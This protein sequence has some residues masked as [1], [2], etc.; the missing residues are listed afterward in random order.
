[1]TFA[2]LDEARL[3]AFL[4]VLA[5][6]G[7]LFAALPFFS[8]EFLPL[9][10]RAVLAAGLSL[11]LAGLVLPAGVPPPPSAAV[12]AALLARE[13][14]LGLAAA[15]VVRLVFAAVEFGGHA[16]GLQMGLGISSVLD[17]RFE[18]EASVLARFQ[19]VLGGFLFVAMGGLGVLAEGLARSLQ[20]VPPGRVPAGAVVAGGLVHLGG[21]VFALG[22]RLAAPV[23]AAVFA[24]QV[25]LGLLARS[26]PAVD[27]LV[28]E[29]PLQILVGLSAFGLSLPHWGPAVVR[30]LAA[31]LEAALGIALLPR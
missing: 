16:A 17:P 1:M 30:A 22:L 12:V 11:S 2:A 28:L 5:R 15:L 23:I 27:V 6:S 18:G 19:V 24:S 26:L 14:V 10:V 20:E 4:L 13:L 21:E 31:G 29:F 25:A 8:G 9:R 7:A 3:F